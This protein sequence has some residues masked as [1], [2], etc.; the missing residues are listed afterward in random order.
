MG[1]RSGVAVRYVVGPGEAQAGSMAECG[2]QDVSEGK[3]P[4]PVVDVDGKSHREAESG[5]T[6]TV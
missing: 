1:R 4:Y 5:S 3:Q 6:L 2:T